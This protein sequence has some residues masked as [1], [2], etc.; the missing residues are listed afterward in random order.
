[1]PAV[2]ASLRDVELDLLRRITCDW[3]TP[4]VDDLVPFV[5]HAGFGTAVVLLLFLLVSLSGAGRRRA[6]LGALTLV[7]TMGAVH[8]V[9]EA[10]WRL[11]PRTRPG[12]TFPEE[13]VLRGPIERLTCAEH[14]EAW[15]E[16][17]HPPKSPAFPSSHAVTIAACAVGLTVAAPWAGILAWVYALLVGYGRLY[18]G[19]HWPTDVLGSLVLT[20]LLGW[21]CARLARRLLPR[22]EARLAGRRARAVA[23]AGDAR[24]A[25][26]LEE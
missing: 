8:G 10:V 13:R 26:S 16:R 23:P 11:A 21:A 25:P 6:V 4:L 9:R 2:L 14:P 19:K 3:A 17:G 5:D 7:L 15:V 20:A 1:V 18:Q 12:S 22:L 24:Q